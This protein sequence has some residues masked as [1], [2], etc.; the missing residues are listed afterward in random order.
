MKETLSLNKNQN[1]K[2]YIN[3]SFKEETD[4]KKL[5]RKKSINSSNYESSFNNLNSE[6]KSIIENE[7][8][9]SFSSN[10]NSDLEE[11][12]KNIEYLFDSKYWRVSKEIS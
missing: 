6:I 4:K 3:T 10:S 2:N 12:K 7:T 8:D 5:E 11:N 1:N 9:L